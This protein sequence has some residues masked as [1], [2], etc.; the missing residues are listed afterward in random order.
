MEQTRRNGNVR[1]WTSHM[2]MMMMMIII[3][4][5]YYLSDLCRSNAEDA[6]RSRLCSAAHGDLQVS[7]SKTKFGDHAFVV[8]RPVSW[9]RLVL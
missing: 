7:C 9:N 2:M 1:L 6:A 8:A 3:I 5:T 4:V